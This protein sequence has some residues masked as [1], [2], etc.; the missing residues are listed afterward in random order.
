MTLIKINVDRKHLREGDTVTLTRAGV[1]VTGLHTR[2]FGNVHIDIK[3]KDAAC[4]DD[5]WDFVSATRMVEAPQLSSDDGRTLMWDGKI[6]YS[7]AAMDTYRDEALKLQRH[8]NESNESHYHASLQ[9]LRDKLTDANTRANAWK[10]KCEVEIENLKERANAIIEDQKV[11][12]TKNL[13][14]PTH[15]RIE[16]NGEVIVDGILATYGYE[17][18][19][20]THKNL[21]NALRDT[22]PVRCRQDLWSEEAS[23]VLKHI[24]EH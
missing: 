3:Y 12:V 14:G 15:V 9:A 21:E 20:I 19:T 2:C 13:Y 4:T 18:K 17:G 8:L 6:W 23:E 11:T 22:W 5:G 7:A 24:R 1:T 10:H 16:R